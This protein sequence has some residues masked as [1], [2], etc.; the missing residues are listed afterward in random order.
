MNNNNNNNN[1]LVVN[2]REQFVENVKQ[3]VTI[4]NQLK[5][6][7][8]KTRIMRERKH[9][10]NQEICDYAI[11]QNIDHKYIEI[12]DGTLK[13]F[14]RKEYK[15][16]TYTFLEKSLSEIISNKEQVSYIINHIKDKREIITHDDI[17]R[18]YKNK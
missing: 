5:I 6:V 10:L 16:I 12:S 13:F 14:K 2:N 8:E 4:D 17:R 3:W 18:N 15:P 1:E 7:N 11:Q 9:K